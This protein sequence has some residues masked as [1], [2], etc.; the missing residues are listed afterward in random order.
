MQDDIREIKVLA[1]VGVVG[2]FSTLLFAIAWCVLAKSQAQK[3]QRLEV[4]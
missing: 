4:R 1:V 3:A 2:I